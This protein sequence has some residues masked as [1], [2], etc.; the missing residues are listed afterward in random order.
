M[1]R[2]TGTAL[3]FWPLMIVLAIALAPSAN[4]GVIICN[5]TDRAPNYNAQTISIAAIDVSIMWDKTYHQL[6][7]Q[8]GWFRLAPGQCHHLWIGARRM[9]SSSYIYMEG[10][11]GGIWRSRPGP[12][13]M[14]F[15]TFE[16]PIAYWCVNNGPSSTWPNGG[17]RLDTPGKCPA[18]SRLVWAEVLVVCA[19]C[20][21]ILDIG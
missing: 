21:Y 15:R 3:L 6:D 8:T 5:K 13:N 14:G 10:S 19:T 9:H 17:V 7:E 2:M 20:D 11:K 12:A 18:G 16:P 4:A 1:T